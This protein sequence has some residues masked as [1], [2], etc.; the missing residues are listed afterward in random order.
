MPFGLRERLA[1]MSDAGVSFDELVNELELYRER[2][3]QRKY[4][5]LWLF[6]WA[7]AKRQVSHPLSHQNGKAWSDLG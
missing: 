5:E 7:L 2:M 3:P 4:D 1:E 6:C